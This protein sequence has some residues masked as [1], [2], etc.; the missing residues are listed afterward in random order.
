M[1]QNS[2]R[3]VFS[4]VG[5]NW[6]HSSTCLLHLTV[7]PAPRSREGPRLAD[8]AWRIS[9]PTH[10]RESRSN[11]LKT[12]VFKCPMRTTRDV[13]SRPFPIKFYEEKSSGVRCCQSKL[14]SGSIIYYYYRTCCNRPLLIRHSPPRKPLYVRCGGTSCSILTM[15]SDPV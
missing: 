14:A 5:D 10:N 9:Y 2:N 11:S 8:V 3:V 12:P 15:P 7:G 4:V 13:D 1:V 6:D